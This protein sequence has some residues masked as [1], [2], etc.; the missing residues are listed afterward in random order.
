MC[1]T[2]FK[3][4]SINWRSTLAKN[5][6]GSDRVVGCGAPAGA[7]AASLALARVC[8]AAGSDDKV[9]LKVGSIGEGEWI[10]YG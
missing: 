2:V 7:L 6:D 1:S 5:S 8:A 4:V 10:E 9:R 3:I